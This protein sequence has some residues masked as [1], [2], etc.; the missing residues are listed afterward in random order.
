M[1]TNI[2]DLLEH[3][4]RIEW[5]CQVEHLERIACNDEAS[6]KDAIEYLR[7]QHKDWESAV[8]AICALVKSLKAENEDLKLLCQFHSK[9]IDEIAKS[10]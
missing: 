9:R 5:D 7:D 1:I 10:L 3:L 2:D 8:K 4:E 6:V